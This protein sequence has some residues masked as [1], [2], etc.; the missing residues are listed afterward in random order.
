MFFKMCL[1]QLMRV[2]EFIFVLDKS[3]CSPSHHEYVQ[4]HLGGKWNTSKIWLKICCLVT[5]FWDYSLK[6]PLSFYKCGNNHYGNHIH[7]QHITWPS[8]WVDI[9]FLIDC[10]I[11]KLEEAI[12]QEMGDGSF[13]CWGHIVRIN[14]IQVYP[15]QEKNINLY[16]KT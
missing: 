2:H 4:T 9:D 1:L 5:G 16:F 12:R 11:S 14:R 10:F 7:N 13:L 15:K 6:M 8:S 3:F